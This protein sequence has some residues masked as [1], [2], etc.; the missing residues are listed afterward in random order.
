MSLNQ[1]LTDAARATLERLGG[2]I[3]YN[4]YHPDGNIELSE[5]EVTD[6]DLQHF[7]FYPGV[8]GLRLARTQVSDA[9]IRFVGEMRDLESLSLHNT[10]ITDCALEELAGLIKLEQLWVGTDPG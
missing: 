10:S 3:E 7:V 8:A 4:E 9:G 6:C 5:S 1:P 2:C